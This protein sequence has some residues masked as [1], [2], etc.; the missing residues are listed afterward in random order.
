[1][2]SG[3]SSYSQNE[4]KTILDKINKNLSIYGADPTLKEVF[5]NRQQKILDIQG[6]Q[7]PLNKT[8][9]FYESDA[10]TYNGIKIIGNVFFKCD[11]NCIEDT[12]EKKMNS[13]VAFSFKSKKGAYLFIN[14]IFELKKELSYD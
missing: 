2:I 14:L 7:I 8:K 12:T 1:L 3:L 11:W 9:E 6:Y 4:V 5:L 10:R 13:G